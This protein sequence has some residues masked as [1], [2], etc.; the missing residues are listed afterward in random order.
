MDA[1]ETIMKKIIIEEYIMK[2]MKCF[3]HSAAMFVLMS[4]VLISGG[5]VF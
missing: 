4:L 1:N 2:K 5:G 3:M